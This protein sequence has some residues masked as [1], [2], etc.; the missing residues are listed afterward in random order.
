MLGIGR[1]Y[2]VTDEEGLYF[3]R[4]TYTGTKPSWVLLK[5]NSIFMVT[6]LEACDN[7][8][9]YIITILFKNQALLYLT[10]DDWLKRYSKH[11]IEL[12]C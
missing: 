12:I 3:Q 6:N 5:T 8:K 7:F 10:D 9:G 4:P 11:E 1:C 2:K